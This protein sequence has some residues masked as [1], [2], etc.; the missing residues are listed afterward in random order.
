MKV[1]SSINVGGISQGKSFDSTIFRNLTDP[2]FDLDTLDWQPYGADQ[3][4]GVD[5]VRLY[6]TRAE[7]PN[8]PA[9]ALLRYHPGAKVA[10]HLHQG[11]ELIFVL[12]GELINDAGVHPAGT[13]EIC[14]PGSE[15][16]LASE[17]GCIFLVVWE[18][19]VKVV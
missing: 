7:D 3:R 14:P 2:A 15:H 9:A 13:L 11:Y 6:D 18:Q 16:A 19:P 5:I 1:L 4:R 8:G 10:C 12:R 17:K